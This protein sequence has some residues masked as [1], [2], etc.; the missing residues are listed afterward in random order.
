M[1]DLLFH[2]DSY[3]KE[4]DAIVTHAA[5][6]G[7]ALDR[8]AFYTAAAASPATPASWNRTGGNTR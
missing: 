3:L 2:A 1:T 8:T 7:V 4:F 5:D 6:S